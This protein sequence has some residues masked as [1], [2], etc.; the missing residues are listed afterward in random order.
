MTPAETA[1]SN[2][3][4]FL[5][6]GWGCFGARQS[7]SA[8]LRRAY[9]A[10]LSDS[11]ASEAPDDEDVVE[12][13]LQ[14]L[15]EAFPSLTPS[16]LELVLED[17]RGDMDR[18][19]AAALALAAAAEQ[20]PAAATPDEDDIADDDGWAMA[21]M[22]GDDESDP[23]DSWE[24]LSAADAEP[25]TDGEADLESMPAAAE[26]EAPTDD[27][28]SSME[29][30]EEIEHADGALAPLPARDDN[31]ELTSS[32]LESWADDSDED[33]DDEDVGEDREAATAVAAGAG[34]GSDDGE[35]VEA[36]PATDSTDS[37]AE[38]GVRVASADGAPVA[39]ATPATTTESSV[40]VATLQPLLATPAPIEAP[41]PAPAA[42]AAA[43]PAP[44]KLL[45]S[46][47]VALPPRAR[48]V[49]PVGV[50]KGRSSPVGPPRRRLYSTAHC[51]C[52]FEDPYLTYYMN[53][54][55][56]EYLQDSGEPT[57]GEMAYEMYKASGGR[58]PRVRAE[59]CPRA[60]RCISRSQLRLDLHPCA[61]L[62]ECRRTRGRRRS[63]ARAGATTAA[64]R[65]SGWRAGWRSMRE[66]CGVRRE[67]WPRHNFGAVARPHGSRDWRDST[68]RRV[69]FCTYQ[70]AC[71]G[72]G[73]V[74]SI[75]AASIGVFSDHCA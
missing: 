66:R 20:Q 43:A 1:S 44:R 21:D 47:V 31:V 58:L 48:P 39:P 71:V 51:P 50:A 18:A 27:A 13:A 5:P 72:S 42:P 49:R 61:R 11:R 56:L 12:P 9:D 57:I 67:G 68:S 23:A 30:W 4:R 53:Q 29:L 62:G 2:R 33:E 38:D 75:Y 37:E 54:R 74:G 6:F 28:S 25:D 55:E 45:F 3:T 60:L 73:V 46:E 22:G 34:S 59:V 10:D 15:A 24:A 14:A 17:A 32:E 52:D 65:R 26:V 63:P 8:V 16:V 36:G 35:L 70:H 19:A 64:R 40:D 7:A 41:A 69:V